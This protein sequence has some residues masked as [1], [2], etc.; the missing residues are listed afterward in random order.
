MRIDTKTPTL[1]PREQ[2]ALE[3]WKEAKRGC[4]GGSKAAV[5]AGIGRQG[6]RLRLWMEMTG[7]EEPDDI[8]DL[9]YVHWGNVLEPVLLQ[10]FF[11]RTPYRRAPDY[12]FPERY[13]GNYA[14]KPGGQTLYRHP[15][16]SW[17][18]YSPDAFALDASGSHGLVETKTTGL[19]MAGDWDD[20]PP[21]A[22]ILQVHHGMDVLGLQWAVLPVLIGGQDFRVYRVERDEELVDTLRSL[23]AQF[24]G[25]VERDVAPPLE[26]PIHPDS[27]A[28]LKK[29]H[30]DDNGKAIVLPEAAVEWDEKL[31]EAKEMRKAVEELVKT[32]EARLRQAMGANT[33][34]HVPGTKVS[35]SLKTTENKGYTRV[36]EPYTYRTLRRK[37]EK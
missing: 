6:S 24:V 25:Y 16:R 14:F 28:A 11:S 20:D 17:Q 32:Y 23:E 1:R 36:V 30:P 7:R 31:Q 18:V 35:Y 34:G 37:V 12:A 27:L 9:E 21:E 29:L 26:D 19:F 33:F 15:A 3:K 5:A 22:A 8:S 2:A 10:Q 13:V 4:I